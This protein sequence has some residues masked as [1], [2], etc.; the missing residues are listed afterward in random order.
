MNSLYKF[1]DSQAFSRNSA[2]LDKTILLLYMFCMSFIIQHLLTRILT[3]L[4]CRAN[5]KIVTAQGK[6]VIADVICYWNMKSFMALDG[7]TSF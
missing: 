3:C 4:A 7:V 1:W 5:A 6:C 2:D